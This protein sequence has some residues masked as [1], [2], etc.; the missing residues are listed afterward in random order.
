VFIGHHRPRRSDAD[1]LAAH[2]AGDR[3]A[4]AELFRR[5]ESP[6]NRLAMSICRTVE[7]A[8]DALQDAMLAA[9]RAAPSF[10]HTATVGSWLYRIVV[11]AS[12]D[13]C[14]RAAAKPVVPL[15]DSCRPMP[16]PSAQVDTAI[17]VRRALL[18]LPVEQR[19][20]VVA[21][22]MLGYSVADTAVM[23][24]I[25]EGT[26]KS[27]CSRARARLAWLLRHHGPPTTALAS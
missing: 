19:T 15:N 11:N 8:N 27:R 1:L 4:F 5:H 21:V 6:L 12:L 9:H 24:R 13:R 26:V 25:A 7:D 17:D 18:Q 14:R 22:D 20:A 2:V 10:K 23:L 16:D 3:Y